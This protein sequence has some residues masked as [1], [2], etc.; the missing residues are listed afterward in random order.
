MIG[1]GALSADGHSRADFSNYGGWVDVYAPGEDLVNAFAV[2]D[3]TCIEEPYETAAVRGA[4]EL[5]WY[6]VLDSAGGRDDRGADVR[7]R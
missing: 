4:G 6:V 7:D 3:Y 2:G 5:E 1:V